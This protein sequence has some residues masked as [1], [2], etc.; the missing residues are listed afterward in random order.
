MDR[1]EMPN[2]TFEDK[3]TGQQWILLLSIADKEQYLSDNPNVKQVLT[4]AAFGDP[5]RLGIRK[6][7]TNFRD[8]LKEIKSHHPRSKGINTF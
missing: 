2:Y 4:A 3:E 7:D 8:V 1:I 5:V 6:P